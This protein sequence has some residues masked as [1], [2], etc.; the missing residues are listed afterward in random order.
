M[1]SNDTKETTFARTDTKID[2][3]AVTLLNQDNAKLLQ[4]S[5]SSFKR[6]INYK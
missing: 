4:Q 6:A 5:K 2:V 3:P 1:L